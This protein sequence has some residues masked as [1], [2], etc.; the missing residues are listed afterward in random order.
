MSNAL[1]TKRSAA[2]TNRSFSGRTVAG[3]SGRQVR[4]VPHQG[5]NEDGRPERC[6]GRPSS[7]IVLPAQVRPAS[8]P[9]RHSS[10]LTIAAGSAPVST[11]F[12]GMTS[13]GASLFLSVMR[14]DGTPANV[15]DAGPV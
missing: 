5:R 11:A 8:P 7:F 2:V 4:T 14:S 1:G 13:A 9:P 10:G 12:G 6:S 3:S 15:S